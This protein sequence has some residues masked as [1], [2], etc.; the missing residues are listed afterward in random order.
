MPSTRSPPRSWPA[1][2]DPCESRGSCVLDSG[3]IQRI[4]TPGTVMGR[5][6]PSDCGVRERAGRTCPTV[7]RSSVSLTPSWVRNG[8]TVRADRRRKAANSVPPSRNAGLG[9]GTR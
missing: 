7:V 1:S 2:S 5:A 9:P 3:F 4:A 8:S 6:W